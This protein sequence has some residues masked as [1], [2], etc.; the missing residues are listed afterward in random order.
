MRVSLI[1][2]TSEARELLILSKSTRLDM[3]SSLIED[4]KNMP[5]EEKE[6]QI[7]YVFGSTGSSLEFV[8]YVFLIEGVSRGFTHQFVRSRVGTSFAQQSLRVV[9]ESDFD[10]LAE[11]SCK[12]D[13]VYHETMSIIKEKY[14]GLI[15]SGKNI[16]DARG[17]LPTNILTNI[18]FKTNLRAMSTMAAMR[19]CIRTQ[20]EY[21]DVVKLMVKNIISVHPWAESA[22]DVYCVQNGTC[23]WKNFDKCPIKIKFGLYED[24]YRKKEIKKYWQKVGTLSNQP[25]VKK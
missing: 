22:L 4:I 19:L 14:R 20:G 15:N 17:I 11:N 10:Y 16:Q 23:P 9:N 25:E 1:N 5:E 21:Q 6:R 3:H 13:E 12:E 8:D 2:Y 18:L 24:T 7:N